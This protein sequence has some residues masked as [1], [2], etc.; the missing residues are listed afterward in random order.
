MALAEAHA[1]PVIPHAGQM[2]NFHIVMAS[3]NSP[4]AR[5]F[6]NVDVEVFNELFWYIFEGEPKPVNGCI[7][8]RND[9]PGFG[10]RIKEEARKDFSV[11]E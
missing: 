11:I 8:L 4:T 1:V 6:P 3:L 2:H 10:L 5:F 7:E 9:V